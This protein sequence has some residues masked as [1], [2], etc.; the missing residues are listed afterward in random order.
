MM[1]ESNIFMFTML[2]LE[3]TEYEKRTVHIYTGNHS[4]TTASAHTHAKT[5]TH[6]HTHTHTHTHTYL[7]RV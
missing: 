7:Y 1:Q 5:Q 2:Q 6:V 4:L 3:I